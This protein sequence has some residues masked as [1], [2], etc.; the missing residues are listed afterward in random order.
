MS[1]QTRSKS[2]MIGCLVSAPVQ[3]FYYPGRIKAIKRPLDGSPG[4]TYS[5][6][7]T[8]PLGTLD[9]PKNELSGS[10]TLVLDFASN[11][12]IG[13]E[14]EPIT[15]A[16]LPENQKVFL[17]Y[18]GREVG[19]RVVRHDTDHDEV[20]LRLDIEPV[21]MTVKL[22]EVRL[23]PSRKSGRTKSDK[24]RQNYSLLASGRRS[25]DFEMATSAPSS[26][27]RLGRGKSGGRRR[28][29]SSS[30]ILFSSN[31]TTTV[32]N[33]SWDSS[34]QSSHQFSYS[35]AS[36]TIE[37]PTDAHPRCVHCFTIFPLS[38]PTLIGVRPVVSMPGV[39]TFDLCAL[40]GWSLLLKV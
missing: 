4:L 3:H 14:F 15:Q 28:T 5:V 6:A 22:T 38:R 26:G 19:A 37:V 18:R 21:E 24:H 27:G 20:H 32:G 10:E 25:P 40:H 39:F 1:S 2:S 23:L 9:E 16:L 31:S 7:F 8:L 11:Q 29:I 17:T 34:S 36:A 30:S 13:R 35:P 33:E 12:L